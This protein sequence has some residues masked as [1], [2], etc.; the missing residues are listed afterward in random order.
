MSMECWVV[1]IRNVGCNDREVKGEKIGNVRMI[2]LCTTTDIVQNTGKSPKHRYSH[3]N[4]KND[5]T[6]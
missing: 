4:N 1:K 3:G 6:A 5:G 2:I